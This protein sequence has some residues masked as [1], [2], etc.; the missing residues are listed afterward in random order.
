MTLL[1]ATI[2]LAWITATVLGLTCLYLH[3]KIKSMDARTASIQSQ[4]DGITMD[5]Y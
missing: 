3:D 1:T 5:Y 4:L 2:A